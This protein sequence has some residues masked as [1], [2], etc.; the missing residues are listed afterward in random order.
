MQLIPSAGK[1]A[2]GTK[3][4]KICNRYQARENMQLVP[5]VSVE[6]HETGTKRGKTRLSQVTLGFGFAPDWLRE[7]D[8]IAADWLD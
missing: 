8:M 5:S 6:K 7:S 3:R 2:T 1:H 4:G